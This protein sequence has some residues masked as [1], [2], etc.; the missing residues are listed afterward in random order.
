M[1][2]SDTSWPLLDLRDSGALTED[3]Y[4]QQKAE[5]L[6]RRRNGAGTSTDQQG[7]RA[8]DEQ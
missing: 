8:S 3:E 6:A 2:W 5:L 7:P 4:R 1:E